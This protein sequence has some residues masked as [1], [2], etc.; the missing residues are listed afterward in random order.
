MA[1]FSQTVQKTP[2]RPLAVVTIGPD[3]WS[4][5]WPDRPAQSVAVGLSA[6]SEA[7]AKTCIGEAVKSA[8]ELLPNASH[9]DG[10]WI[11]A[12]NEALILW[13]VSLSLCNPNEPKDTYLP[14]QD[15]DT[16]AEAF[17]PETIRHFWD[18]LERATVARSP[19][20]NEATNEELAELARLL[21]SGIVDS[22]ATPQAQRLRKLCSFMLDELI[23]V[24]EALGEEEGEA[25][26]LL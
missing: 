9:F 17:R 22:L 23:V 8:D 18:E 4:S 5:T 12:R 19:I 7:N 11:D 16:V 26:T 13:V 14:S 3:D 25:E 15:P 20:R 10:D 24:S 1:A 21:T 2:R 6:F